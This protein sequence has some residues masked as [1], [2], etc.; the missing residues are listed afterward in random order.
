MSNSISDIKTAK[1]SSG[2]GVMGD[3]AAVRCPAEFVG[4]GTWRSCYRFSMFEASWHE[5][6]EYCSAFGANLLT[7][8]TMKEAYII[9]Y[10]IKSNTG[11]LAYIIDYLILGN[12]GIFQ[13]KL[14]NKAYIIDYQVYRHTS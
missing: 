7:L 1:K 2:A 6:K 8:E 11:K 3:M 14:T 10:L 13:L 12:T 4:V 5:A 9:D